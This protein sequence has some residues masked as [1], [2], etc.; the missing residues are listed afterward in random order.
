MNNESPLGK[1]SRYRNQ[2]EPGLLFAI[3][4]RASRQAIG[5]EDN[6]PFFG[7]DIWTAWELTWLNPAGVPQVAV[8]EFRVPFDSPCLIESKSLKLYLNSFTMSRYASADAL[9][10]VIAHDL[11][12]SAGA[13]VEVRLCSPAAALPLSSPPGDC[14]DH[15]A[16]RCD[17]YDVDASLLSAGTAIVSE[18]LYSHLLRSLCPV[19]DQPDLGSVL[20]AYSGPQIDRAGLLRYIVSYREHNDFHEACVE[21]MFMDILRRCRPTQLSVYARFQRRG[22]IDINPFRSNFEAM[23]ASFRLP[24]Q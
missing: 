14:I 10:D 6:F 17:V 16:A 11:S 12:S 19:T 5:L 23:P 20:I 8:A 24:R 3:A 4:R 1:A 15:I 2:Y 21:R 9:R 18:R 22:G 7:S 13:A